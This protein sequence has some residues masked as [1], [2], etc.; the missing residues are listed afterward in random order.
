MVK[1]TPRPLYARKEP[2]Y[3]WSRRLGTVRT[4]LENLL[5]PPGLEPGLLQLLNYAGSDI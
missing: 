3:Q 2:R 5:P 1:A 4:G